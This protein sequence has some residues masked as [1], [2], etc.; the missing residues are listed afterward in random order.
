MTS[1]ECTKCCKYKDI[2]EMCLNLH[3]LEID[4][5]EK[6]IETFE[7]DNG[8]DLT[9]WFCHSCANEILKILE[10]KTYA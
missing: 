3:E 2:D 6:T 4:V 10:N 7:K 1:R 5:T 9:T 8:L